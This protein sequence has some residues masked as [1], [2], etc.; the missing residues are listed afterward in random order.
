LQKKAPKADKENIRHFVEGFNDFSRHGGLAKL[1]DELLSDMIWDLWSFY[2]TRQPSEAKVDINDIEIE[3]HE[4]SSRV[5]INVVNDNMSFLVDSLTGYL[6]HIGLRA[7]VLLRPI[8]RTRRDENGKITEFVQPGES[9]KNSQ[10][11]SIIH[12]HITDPVSKDVMKKLKSD[13]EAIQNDVTLANADWSV[14]RTKIHVGIKDLRPIP[15]ILSADQVAEVIDFLQWIDND[16]FTFL[17]Y[18]EYDLTSR[19]KFFEATPKENTG[20]GILRSQNNQDIGVFYHGV[21][22]SASTMRYIFRTDPI[23]VTKTTRVSTVHRAVPMDS[24]TVKQFDES[25]RVIGIRQ[26]LGLFTSMAY[27]S[28]A[29]DIPLLRRKVLRVVDKAGFSPQW[30]DGKG[31]IHILDS[32]PRD[33]LFQASEDDL[34]DIGLQV[35]S[36]Q[37]R[38]RLAF[39]IRRDHFE[40][41]LSCMVY[42][43]RD[44][45][46]Y[47]LTERMRDILEEELGCPVKL[48]SAQYGNL[49]FARA[50]YMAQ[51][52]DKNKTEYD[53]KKIEARLAKAAHSWRDGLRNALNDIFGEWQGAKVY[54]SYGEAFNKGYQERF[55]EEEAVTDIQYIEEAFTFNNVGVRLYRDHSKHKN[56]L[57]LKLYHIGSALP[58]SDVLPLLRNMDLRII[59]EVPFTVKPAHK[60]ETIWIHDFEAECLGECPVKLDDIREK[61]ISM[62]HRV[63]YNDAENDGFNRLVLRTGLDWRQCVML[64][65]YGKYLKQIKTPFS[66]SYMEDTLLKN[67]QITN[68]IAELFET[69]FNPEMGQKESKKVAKI[70]KEITN[71]LEAVENPDEDRIL[72]RFTNLIM[73]TVRTN[74]FQKDENGLPMA[75]TSY[76]FDSSVI[77]D[78]PPPRP[79]YEIFVYSPRF[80]SV[81]L[82]GG[83]VARGGIRWS[84][85]REDFRTEIL[86]LVKAQMVKNA[87]IVPQG[88]KGGFVLKQINENMTREEFQE[89]GVTCYKMMMRS[90]LELTDNLVGGKVIPPK[91]T[92]RWDEDDP[93]LVVAADKGTATFSDFANGI[94][95]EKGFWLRDA[96]ASGGSAGYDHKKMGITARGA[97]ESVL[98]HFREMNI[99]IEEESIT[100]AGIGDMGGDVFGNGMLLNSK[101]KVVAAFN[102]KHI[103]IDPDPDPTKSF[104]ERQRCFENRLGWD[105]YN[106]KLISK[107][108]GVFERRAKTITLSAEAKK[109]LGITKSQ[110][111][112]NEVVQ[113][114]LMSEVDLLWFGGIGTYIK[115]KFESD[116]SVGDRANDAVRIDA[117]HLKCRVIGEGANLGITQRGRI[118]FAGIGGHVNTDAIDN[119]A[120]VDCSD[121]EVNIK[122]L[123]SDVIAGKKLSLKK[124]NELL[125]SMTDEVASLVLRNNYDQNLALSLITAQGVKLLDLQAKLMRALEKKGVLDRTLE[126]L[127]DDSSLAD[128]QASQTLLSRPELSVIIAY[129]KNDIYD[130]L[131]NSDVAEDPLLAHELPAYFPEPIQQQYGKY[132]QKHPLRNE[133]IATIATNKIVNRMGGSFVQKCKEKTDKSSADVIR[134]FYLTQKVYNF[135]ELWQEIDSVGSK[136]GPH[137]QIQCFLRLIWLKKRIILWILSHFPTPLDMKEVTRLFEQGVKSL[138]P[139]LDSALATETKQKI[140]EDT[141]LYRSKGLSQSLARQLARLETMVASAEIFL[142]AKQLNQPVAKIAPVFFAVG[143]RFGFVRLR[144]L[145]QKVTSTSV[146]QRSAIG[147]M[148]EDLYSYQGSLAKKI[149][150]DMQQHKGAKK[151][152]GAAIVENWAKI[153]PRNMERIDHILAESQLLENPDHAFM[154]V[155]L[156]EI[157]QLCGA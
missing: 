126:Y 112:P 78:L 133:I 59:G 89:E 82:R 114:I 10:Q 25:G 64:R 116:S 22:V 109:L 56:I 55:D 134:A 98:R 66:Q 9:L 13:I 127:P 85:R 23:V 86:G 31:I 73:A 39:F 5:I 103:F 2:Q 12:C 96:F 142:I 110:L 1:S 52:S 43:P 74:F 144:V 108:G 94:S 37:E 117:R 147:F 141:E 46:D 131:I 32:L 18:R 154:S 47:E 121:H 41:F 143:A 15:G 70:Q 44:R 146:W 104:K 113:H 53:A 57:K 130:E 21:P 118:E 62:F 102:H 129:A 61:F 24:I 115:S 155:I 120:G 8:Y 125:E 90:M 123:L 151:F 19:K 11:E 17:G 153:N 30:H 97:W 38:P 45:F 137:N 157:R 65:S 51:T 119:S 34:L 145:T 124:R 76:K 60:D 33:E 87:V 101:M 27:S 152:E 139:K 122:I 50:H 67:P 111:H 42:I 92:V 75:T 91:D 68:L 54:G 100:V 77:S 140:A 93:Y 83:K 81:H 150:Q 20:L 84:D 14:M 16:H 72:R 95:E 136:I 58:L 3:P 132:I 105:G 99:D 36:I 80:E 4:G 35:L 107:G 7:R 138:E 49:T 128:Y 106:E 48:S 156:R 29:R 26:F 79:M 135:D 71:K 88:S 148:Q 69:R 63:F 6:G 40:R 28:S 149:W